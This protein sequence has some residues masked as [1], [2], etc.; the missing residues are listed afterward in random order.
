MIFPNQIG[1]SMSLVVV[2][3]ATKREPPVH[4]IRI[5]GGSTIRLDTPKH[6]LNFV[7]TCMGPR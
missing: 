6:M 3:S 1:F 4:D 7:P 5:A 2:D